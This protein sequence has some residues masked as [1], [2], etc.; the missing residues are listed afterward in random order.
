M[1]MVQHNY[2]TSHPSEDPNE[3]MG[4]FLRMANTVKLN[5]VRPGVIKLQSFPFFLRAATVSWFESLPYGSVNTW[6]E[7]VE[8]FM[9]RFFSPALTSERKG[10]I[11]IFKQGE[12]ESLY[13]A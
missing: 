4:R 12:D 10:E 7:L 1:T 11:I 13:N 6:D 5:G 2:F 9:G 8:P 3:Y